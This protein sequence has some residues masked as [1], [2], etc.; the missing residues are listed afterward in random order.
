MRGTYFA[1]DLG[2]DWGGCSG[3]ATI[4][5]DYGILDHGHSLSVI[6]VDRKLGVKQVHSC[7][8]TCPLRGEDYN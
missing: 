1:R 2:D 8:C 7:P 5:R 4:C 6:P 3:H